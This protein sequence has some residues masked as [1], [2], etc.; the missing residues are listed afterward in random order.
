[1]RCAS[2]SMLEE[3]GNRGGGDGV[4][5]RGVEFR[6]PQVAHVVGHQTAGDVR[7]AAIAAR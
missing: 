1:M 4:R 6:D 3:M 5:R 7:G 2:A